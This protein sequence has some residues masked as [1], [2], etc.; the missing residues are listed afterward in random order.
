LIFPENPP[1]LD[2]PRLPVRYVFDQYSLD[3]DKQELRRGPDHLVPVEPQVFDLLAFLIQNRDRVVSAH[4]LVVAIWNGRSVSDSTVSS[5]ISA[6]R[7]A[8]GDDGKNKRLIV[9]LPRKGHRFLGNLQEEVG[10]GR[11][12]LPTLRQTKP[13]NPK[14]PQKQAI[15]FCKTKDNVNIAVSTVGEG[16][17]LVRTTHWLSHVEYD[18]HSPV[19]APSVHALAGFSRLVRYDGRGIGLS[20]RSV[21]LISPAT[22]QLDLEAVVDSLGLERFALLG[23]SQGAATALTYAARHPDRVSKVIVHGSYALGRN[24]RGAASDIE[25]SK[26]MI[27]VMRRGWGD[28][29]SAFM[30]A[31]VT[32][33]LPNGTPEQVKA[34]ADLQRVATSPENAVMIRTMIDEADIREILPQVRSPT[35]VF[36]SR[37]DNVVP[38]EQGRLVAASIPN[39]RFVPLETSN[40]VLVATEPAFAQFIDGIKSFLLDPS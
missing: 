11:G 19:T 37:H 33:F 3:T 18:W 14:L 38:F 27:S 21:P 10:S 31:F 1:M 15:T 2:W 23:T 40:H 9:T 28:E 35:I 7:R 39:A 4:E 30:R 34:Y 5:R 17:V 16:E 24:K 13:E 26:M 8:I 25:E 20:D 6:A 29:H 12:D 32:L 22:L 36:H